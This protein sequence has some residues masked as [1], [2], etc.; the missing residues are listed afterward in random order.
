MVS[1]LESPYGSDEIDEYKACLW[2]SLGLLKQP[3]KK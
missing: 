3:N 1:G 2:V